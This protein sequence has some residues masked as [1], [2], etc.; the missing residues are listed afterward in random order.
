MEL[1]LPDAGTSGSSVAT[2]YRAINVRAYRRVTTVA[3]TSEALRV[4]LLE[5]FGVEATRATTILNGADIDVF[6]PDVERRD[7]PAPFDHYCLFVGRLDARG[8]RPICCSRRS[9]KRRGSTACSPGDGPERRKLEA[10]GR[11]SS[12]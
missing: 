2:I 8:R 10:A 9:W 6:N 7:S 4:E 1:P 3:T 5:R 12:A 11:R